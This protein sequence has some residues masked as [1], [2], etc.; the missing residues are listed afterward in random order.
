MEKFSIEDLDDL[1]IG[2]GTTTLDYY[3]RNMIS[4][5]G[6]VKF[7]CDSIEE[8]KKKLLKLKNTL[9]KEKRE[10]KKLREYHE[11]VMN[12]VHSLPISVDDFIGE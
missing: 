7:Y 5:E 1:I 6:Q 2:D 4:L 11:K 10:H 9:A 12:A 3:K 8:Y